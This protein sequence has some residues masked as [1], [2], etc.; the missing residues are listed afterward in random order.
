M[1]LFKRTPKPVAP[2]PIEQWFMDQATVT[3]FR[4]LMG[5]D[6]MRLAI[7]VLQ[8]AAQPSASTV[9]RNTPEQAAT[10]FA[11]LAGYN[12]AFNDLRK[13]THPPVASGNQEQEWDY[14][15]PDSITD[16]YDT[17]D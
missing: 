1:A 15:L 17:T 12:D 11:W 3:D 6:A 10:R 2:V 16:L 8:N 5:S 14:V 7:A 9:V 4:A 13:L